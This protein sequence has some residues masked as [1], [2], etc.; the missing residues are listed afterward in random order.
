MNTTHTQQFSNRR[1]SIVLFLAVLVGIAQFGLGQFPPWVI[2]APFVA[3]LVMEVEGAWKAAGSKELGAG[4]GG[5]MLTHAATAFVFH[6]IVIGAVMTAVGDSAQRSS[7]RFVMAKSSGGGCGSG[8]MC[9]GGQATVAKASSA[10]G[11][12]SGGCGAAAGGCGSGGCGAGGSVASSATGA[13][14]AC[15]CGG[16]KEGN[17]KAMM[18]QIPSDAAKT[19]NANQ[20]RPGLPPMMLRPNGAVPGVTNLPISISPQAMAVISAQPK[21]T[22]PRPGQGPMMKALVPINPPTDANRSLLGSTAAPA[23]KESATAPASQTPAPLKAEDGLPKETKETKEIKNE[24][25]P[26]DQ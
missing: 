9:G 5:G 1:W 16:A 13:K 11:C 12:G 25:K 10:G 19:P 23:G 8:G 21:T 14:S 22:V 26:A 24:P 3:L 2:A 20:M 17:A 7:G 18:V 4:S 15:G 6:G